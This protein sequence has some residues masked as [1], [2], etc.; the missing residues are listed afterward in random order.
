MILRLA[1]AVSLTFGIATLITYLTLLGKGP[2]VSREAHHLRAMKDR[3]TSPKTFVP[4]TIAELAAL[5]K[6]ARLEEY[7]PIE[8]RGV[9]VEGW[10]ERIY[11]AVDADLHLDLRGPGGPLATYAVTELTPT[12]RRG[13]ARWSH[14]R[15]IAELRPN[16]GGVTPWDGG[17]RRVRLSGWLLNDYQHANR[18]YHDPKPANAAW[19][20]HPITRIER[21]DDASGR[22]VEYPR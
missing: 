17:P 8:A 20:V 9:S 1:A 7:A 3:R 19:E 5:P 15:L 13:S 4:M 18:P 16:R 14:E 2:L 12:W 11:P 22:F 6:G 10:V 21:W